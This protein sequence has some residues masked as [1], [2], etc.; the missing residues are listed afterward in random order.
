MGLA[1]APEAFENL[2]ELSLSG[3]SYEIAL[4]YLDYIIIFGRSYKEPLERMEFNLG[5][6]KEAEVK[7]KGSNEDSYKRKFILLDIVCRTSA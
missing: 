3:L 5:R 7:I 6:L 4:V 1:S 2:L